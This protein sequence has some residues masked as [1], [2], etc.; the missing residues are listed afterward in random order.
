[1]VLGILRRFDIEGMISARFP[2]PQAA[3]AY[4]IV[5]RKEAPPLQAVFVYP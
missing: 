4:A 1:V 2:L 3:E 5:D